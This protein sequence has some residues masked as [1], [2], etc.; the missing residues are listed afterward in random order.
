MVRP[1]T[2]SRPKVVE[3][4]AVKTPPLPGGA[5][6]PCLCQ[7]RPRGRRPQARFRSICEDMTAAQR[8]QE[9]ARGQ[10]QPRRYGLKAHE[11]DALSLAVVAWI[12]KSDFEASRIAE[13]ESANAQKG[14][15][16]LAFFHGD[17]LYR[18]DGVPPIRL[19]GAQADVLEALV[20]THA[21]TKDR[22][23]SSSGHSDAPRVLKSICASFPQLAPFITL[24]GRKGKGGYSTTIRPA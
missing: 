2:S 23:I 9:P 3:R 7:T 19:E 22:L 14:E 6:V 18:V 13:P 20:E 16:R 15:E 12:L 17:G 8:Q 1:R 21:A 24:P 5:I 10:R 11:A 4:Q